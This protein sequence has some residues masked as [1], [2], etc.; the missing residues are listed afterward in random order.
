MPQPA[1]R[2]KVSLISQAA[3][4][5]FP[6][7]WQRSFEDTAS[8]VTGDRNARDQ[9]DPARRFRQEDAMT[10]TNSKRTIRM[11]AY[12][13]ALT[14]VMSGVALA[15]DDDDYYRR[16]NTDQARQYGYQNGYDDGLRRGQ[17]E[18]RENDP[19][20]YQTPEWRQATRG[21]QEWMGPMNWY[22]RGY[23]EG[24]STGFRAGYQEVAQNW[25]DGDDRGQHYGWRA[26]DRD[27]VAYRMGYEDGSSVAREDAAQWKPY[28]P[29]PR[30]RYDDR[31]HG[32]RREYGSKDQ[33]KMEYTYGYRDGYQSVRR[34][35]YY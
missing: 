20:D 23:Q 19:F 15:H 34:G 6:E 11:A 32:Y 7:S 5:I 29:K 3:R 2:E 31:D 14:L 16:G 24:Y 1:L 35:R 21:Y 4:T 22:Q 8:H 18:G 27:S 30:G 28:N 9:R 25:Y 13:L 26:R 33:Y 12:A 10:P 17:H